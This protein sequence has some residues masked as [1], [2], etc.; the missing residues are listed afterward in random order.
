MIEGAQIADQTLNTAETE[1]MLESV[2][3]MEVIGTVK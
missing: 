2:V 1:T 3:D